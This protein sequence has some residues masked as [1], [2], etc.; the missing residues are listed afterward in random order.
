M[1]S[2]ECVLEE[3][4]TLVVEMEVEHRRQYGSVQ[5]GS[6]LFTDRRAVF[7]YQS[8]GAWTQFGEADLSAEPFAQYVDG[9]LRAVFIPATDSDAVLQLRSDY[10]ADSTEV[11]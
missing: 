1:S 3:E 4:E 2:A 7:S 10:I 5:I 6:V 8:N 11:G 9:E